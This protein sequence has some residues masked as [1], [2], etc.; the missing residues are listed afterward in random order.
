MTDLR[1]SGTLLAQ[2]FRFDCDR[3]LRWEM[4]PP[5][6]RGGD[7]P[8]PNADPAAGP[9][10]GQRPGMELLTRAGRRWEARAM[11]RLI[12]H[13]G[14]RVVVADRDAEGR[15]ERL[16]YAAVV[17]ALRDPGEARWLVQP[18]LRVPDGFRERF[19]IPVHV[20][21]APAQPDLVRLGRDARGRLR[22]GVADVKWSREG[23]LQH[24]AQVAFYSLLLEEIC[25]AEGIEAVVDTRWGWLWT[26]GS[27]GPK[28][29]PLAAYRH[30]VQAFLRDE[31]PRIAAASAAEAEWHLR[32]RCTSCAFFAHCRAEADRTDHLSRVVGLTPLAAS[33]LR[34]RGIRNVRQLRTAE[35]KR[36]VYTGAHALESAESVLKKRVQALDFGKLK[37]GEKQSFR[38]P[39]AEAARVLVTAESDPVSGTVFALGIRAERSGGPA[40][41]DVFVSES[42]SEEGER[43]MLGRFLT[44]AAEIVGDAEAGAREAQTGGRRRGPGAHVYLWD[45][46]EAELLRDCLQRHLGDA[47]TQPGIAGVARLLF[48]GGDAGAPPP[49]TVVLDVVGE[50]FALPIPYAWDLASVSD[51]LQPAEKAWVHRTRPDY[52]WPFSSQV[53]FERIHDVWRQRPHP[54]AGGEE[55]PERVRA[56]IVRAVGS[57]L[58]G[59]DSVIRA[60]RDHAARRRDPMLRMDS[61]AFAEGGGPIADPVLEQLRLFTLAEAAEQAASIRALHAL[62][63]ADR[64]RR[65]ESISGLNLVERLP[66]GHAVFEFDPA[67]RE[68]KFRPGDFA[69]VLTNDDGRMLA[70]TD[71]K[72]WLRRKLM[73]ELIDYDLASSPPRITLAPDTAWDKLAFDRYDGRPVLDLNRVCVLDRASVDFNTR[74]VVQS[75]RAL[76]GDH[77]ESATVR[78]LLAGQAPGW[79][80]PLDADAGWRETVDVAHARRGYALNAE[81]EAAWRAA[82]GQSVSVIWGP[83]GTGKTYLLAW[84][85][86]GMAAAARAAGRPLRILVTAATHRAVVN[87]LARLARELASAGLDSPLRAV[88]LAGRGS[89]ADDDLAA[90]EVEVIRDDHLPRALAASD[91]DGLPL[92]AGSTV[93]SLWKQM[94]QMNGDDDDEEADSTVPIRPLFDVVV[95]D[96]ASQMKVPEALIALSSLRPG[97][98]VVLCGDDRQLPPI[99]YGRYPREETL[100][101]SAFTHFAERFGRLALR[102]SRRMNRALV[103]WPARLFYPGFVSMDPHR[104]L[105]RN[106]AI[107]IDDPVD[108]LLWDVLLRPGDAAVFCT[109]AGVRATARNAFEAGLAARLARLARVGIRDPETGAAYTAEAFRAHG[110]AILSPHRAQNAAILGELVSGG[111]P[112][113]ELPVVDTVE[114]MQGNEREMIIVSYAV[115]DREYAEREA[116]FL[117]N[118]NRFNVSITR[119]RSKLV[120]LMSDD[121]LRTMPRDEQTLTESMAIKGYPAHFRHERVIEV[122]VTGASPVR[123][124]VRT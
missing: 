119:P 58:A 62:P 48:P 93:W 72:P 96:E 52:G 49:G 78:A 108:R 97:G 74:R 91:A 109:Y 95:I 115:A 31:L 20:R 38:M 110:L 55:A 12:A 60:I 43:E 10:I 105:A 68:A 34:S 30:H 8:A 63:T 24:F 81:Q 57:K 86:I 79:A 120:V 18:E 2:Y 73:V 66:N 35:F 82:F 104:R 3:Q 121:V 124:I 117:L 21:V 28:R 37:E 89:E 1:L 107:E 11:D 118:P 6:L 80:T 75:L 61:A 51:E 71:A 111:W 77:G 27:R 103:R 15:T 9:L 45:A 13:F 4:V 98:R 67:C 88:K 17:R 36:G 99:L 50:L 14:E 46:G 94:R 123:L 69:L 90:L 76:A 19:G 33:Q 122:E 100:F 101:G 41:T 23:A 85:L 44:R 25:R 7:V 64:A 113:G 32:P 16:P 116:E 56:E 5:A 47:G 42:G 40:R 59:V 53:A 39:V 29:F 22:L 112:R 87:V 84:I 54:V 70:E 26:R 102:E 92:V 83:P 65:F 106:E 114:R